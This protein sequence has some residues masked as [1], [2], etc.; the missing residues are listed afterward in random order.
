MMAN[1]AVIMWIMGT[2]PYAMLIVV[3]MGL[4]GRRGWGGGVDEK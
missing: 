1:T 3:K 2:N 4:V